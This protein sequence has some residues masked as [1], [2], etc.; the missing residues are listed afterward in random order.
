[1]GMQHRLPTFSLL[2]DRESLYVGKTPISWICLQFRLVCKPPQIS[3]PRILNQAPVAR[4]SIART[5]P[6]LLLD[7]V[8][9]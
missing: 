8:Y 3:R 5:L 4:S 2:G 9:A 7:Q 6:S 1:M